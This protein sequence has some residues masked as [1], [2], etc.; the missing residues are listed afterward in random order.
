MIWEII[1]ISSHLCFLSIQFARAAS[2]KIMGWQV[3]IFLFLSSLFYNSN[4]SFYLFFKDLKAQ[5][6]DTCS[7]IWLELGTPR[8]LYMEQWAAVFL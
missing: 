7:T 6:I 1:I 2:T 5:A 8:Y 3:F 4:S